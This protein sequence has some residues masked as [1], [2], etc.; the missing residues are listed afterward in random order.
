MLT[1]GV[2][3]IEVNF[4]TVFIVFLL[5]RNIIIFIKSII[6]HEILIYIK[7]SIGITACES[8]WKHKRVEFLGAYRTK[9][10]ESP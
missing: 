1:D 7:Y 8:V 5:D 9:I 10:K 6:Y 2:V 3:Y 4:K